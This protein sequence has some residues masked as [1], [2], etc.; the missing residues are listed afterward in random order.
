MEEDVNF[1]N[2]KNQSEPVSGLRYYDREKN[3]KENPRTMI[4]SILQNSIRQ[5]MKKIV[6]YTQDEE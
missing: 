1:D 4:D 3:K 2:H 6:Q 5:E